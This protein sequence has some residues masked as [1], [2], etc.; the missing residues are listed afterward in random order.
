[1]YAVSLILDLKIAIEIL[2]KMSFTDT[3]LNVSDFIPQLFCSSPYKTQPFSKL[4]S[5][6]SDLSPRTHFKHFKDAATLWT[7]CFY[8][9]TFGII[10]MNE[11]VSVY[12]NK[13]KYFII[14]CNLLHLASCCF[15][16][17]QTAGIKN[18]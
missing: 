3:C 2:K 7:I 5:Y 8:S 16:L 14:Q 10:K 17:L 15:K 13:T 12:S 6:A 4:F 18:K 9:F 1:M 11:S